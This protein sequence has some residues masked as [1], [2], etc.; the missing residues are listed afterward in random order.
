MTE[1]RY[2][3]VALADYI[4]RYGEVPP[5]DPQGFL[6]EALRLNQQRQGQGLLN[7]APPP[8]QGWMLGPAA[9]GMDVPLA[10]VISPMGAAMVDRVF[11]ENGLGYLLPG[12]GDLMDARDAIELGGQA[13]GAGLEGD[14]GR[15]G[16]AA[17]LAAIAAM[18]ALPAVDAP[19]VKGLL[20]EAAEPQ[21]GIRAYH[22]SPHDFDKF[23]MEKIGTGE[24]AQ[25]YGH[26]LYFAEKEGVAKS[27]Q[28][29][30]SAVANMKYDGRPIKGEV[31]RSVA[32]FLEQNG[33]S[34]EAV[35]E[36]WKSMYKPSHWETRLG[37]L[38]LRTLAEIDPAKIKAGSMYEVNIAANPDDFI[39]WDKPLAEQSE[40]VR[41]ALAG[42]IGNV[43][44]VGADLKRI[45]NSPMHAGDLVGA[46]RAL[47]PDVSKKLA[48]MGIPGIKYLDAGSRGAKE[49]TRNYV[50]FDDKLI[51]ILRKYGIAGLL[52]MSALAGM[53]GEEAQ[54]TE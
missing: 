46:D 23:S 26:G 51:S 35:L 14:W 44:P 10:E 36:Q 4:N 40:K 28:A 25:A 54:A 50:V 24:G 53:G 13:I 19:P 12:T 18:G 17:G 16:G 34:K 48:E 32:W 9:L 2:Q 49:G 20:G 33:G 52:G 6:D 3:A 29:N 47:P 11:G 31:K 45:Y 38:E 39:D 7:I 37:K 43:Q 22:G 30:N 41:G 5:P 27:Y 1:P 21:Q 42:K 15:M 8:K